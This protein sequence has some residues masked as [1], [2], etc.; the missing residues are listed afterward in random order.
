MSRKARDL[1]FAEWHYW[2][3]LASKAM[4]GEALSAHK[5]NYRRWGVGFDDLPTEV[6]DQLLLHDTPRSAAAKPSE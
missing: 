6:R 1:H 5:I 3:T 2:W 4:R